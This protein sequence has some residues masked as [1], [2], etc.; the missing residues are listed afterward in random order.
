MRRA[1]CAVH[2]RARRDQLQDAEQLCAF[3]TI[4]YGP[5]GKKR[6][7]MTERSARSL[8]RSRDSYRL[9]PS[10]MHW[11]GRQLTAEISEWC[12]PMPRKMSGRVTVTP[13]ALTRHT[14]LLDDPGRHRWHPLAPIARVEVDFPGMGVRWSGDGYLDCNEGNE[15]LADGFVGWDWA[16]LRMN[17]D[18]CTVRY[19]TRPHM[20]QPRRLSLSFDSTGGMQAIKPSD[21]RALQTTGVWRIPRQVPSSSGY[22]DRLERT[23]EDTPFY[24]RSL[25]RT[26]SDGQHGQG[27]HES[28][29]MNRF[30]QPWVQTL[31]PFRMPRI[32]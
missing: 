19:E 25:L 9:G 5:R 10:A 6:W 12:V 8:Q 7:S 16:R 26:A 31:L 15:P 14:V 24:A 3:N 20:S 27:F 11:D 18:E 22:D 29:C 4:L 23:L 21:S 2:A 32:R 28:L 17:D 1:V 13:S 30:E